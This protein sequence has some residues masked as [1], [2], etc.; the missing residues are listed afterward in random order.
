MGCFYVVR[1]TSNR[2][3]YIVRVSAPGRLS[4]APLTSLRINQLHGIFLFILFTLLL[5]QAKRNWHR[6][7]EP[8]TRKR[9]NAGFMTSRAQR[10]RYGR[11]YSTSS[12]SGSLLRCLAV[13][14][15]TL[16]MQVPKQTEMVAVQHLGPVL[17]SIKITNGAQQYSACC[18]AGLHMDVPAAKARCSANLRSSHVSICKNE[19][20]DYQNNCS[21]ITSHFDCWDF[22]IFRVEARPFQHVMTQIAYFCS[23][24]E[25]P[26]WW[27][28]QHVLHP[29]PISLLWSHSI[30][31]QLH[32]PN[33][34]YLTWPKHQVHR[35][36]AWIVLDEE[37]KC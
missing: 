31:W 2:L 12:I 27:R 24:L 17:C 11:I 34:S 26:L 16:F 14:S 18:L 9:Q 32:F 15:H 4:S 13:L 19:N 1:T 6:Q 36:T 25:G 23:E 20:Q 28:I 21:P 37:T 30:A 35:E 7:N 29:V 33:T 8:Q 22:H 5:H 3:H 10:I